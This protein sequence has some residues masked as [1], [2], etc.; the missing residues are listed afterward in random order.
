M[1]EKTLVETLKKD[2]IRTGAMAAT[3]FYDEEHVKALADMGVDIITMCTDS[4]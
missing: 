3:A 2:R 4:I 1:S